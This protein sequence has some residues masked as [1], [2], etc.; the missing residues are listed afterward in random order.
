[1]NIVSLAT[2]KERLLELPVGIKFSEDLLTETRE[3]VTNLRE[4][5]ARTE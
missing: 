3:S 5:I 2:T 4:A 1:M